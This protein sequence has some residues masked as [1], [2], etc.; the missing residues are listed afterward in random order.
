MTVLI[1]VLAIVIGWTAVGALLL[2]VLDLRLLRETAQGVVSILLWPVFLYQQIPSRRRRRRE[3]RRLAT[4]R[5]HKDVVRA[6]GSALGDMP[7]S[8]PLE[9]PLR[10]RISA[11]I[12]EALDAAIDTAERGRTP[13]REYTDAFLS[14]CAVV[15]GVFETAETAEDE[16]ER[17]SMPFASDLLRALER[18]PLT[19]PAGVR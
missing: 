16:G 18:S 17:L 14:A 3:G 6:I 8:T 11:A 15:D 4:L 5:G 1:D 13:R 9:H 7:E 2:F 12:D 10:A 19:G